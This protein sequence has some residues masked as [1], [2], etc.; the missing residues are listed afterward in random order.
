MYFMYFKVY[1]NLI[2]LFNIRLMY[3]IQ[4]QLTKPQILFDNYIKT[5]IFAV[6]KMR[7]IINV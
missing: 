2:F 4:S 3:L 1:S 7:G 6:P 5:P